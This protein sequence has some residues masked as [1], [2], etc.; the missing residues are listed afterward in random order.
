[1]TNCSDCQKCCQSGRSR[2]VKGTV[3]LND[4]ISQKYNNLDQLK[5]EVL[6][7]KGV[8][9]VEIDTDTKEIIIYFDDVLINLGDIKKTIN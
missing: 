9:E 5:A 8:S 4:N 7:L 3:N 2:L 6:K 1:M